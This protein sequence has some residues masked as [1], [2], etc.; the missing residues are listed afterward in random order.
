MNDRDDLIKTN[1]L[2]L[3]KIVTINTGLHVN[4]IKVEKKNRLILVGKLYDKNNSYNHINNLYG[5]DIESDEKLFI[6]DSDEAKNR[7]STCFYCKEK[8]LIKNL[9]FNGLRCITDL[10]L[11]NDL[12]IRLPRKLS[13]EY[14]KYLAKA[15]NKEATN[16]LAKK[17]VLN[18]DFIK[19]T[20]HKVK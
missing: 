11:L 20:K 12:D 6:I 13:Y 2:A 19:R 17:L 8:G 16:D 7:Y 5:L 14:I 9:E 10:V 4:N 3:A 18:K 15:S 1:R